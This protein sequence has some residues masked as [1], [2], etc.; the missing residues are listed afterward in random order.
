MAKHQ[1][2]QLE[3]ARTRPDGQQIEFIQDLEAIIEKI[4]N[5]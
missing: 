5:S 3:N 4:E 1:V 2:R